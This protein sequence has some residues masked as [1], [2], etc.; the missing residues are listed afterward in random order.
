MKFSGVKQNGKVEIDLF[1][2]S[3]DKKVLNFFVEFSYYRR[4]LRDKLIITPH[5]KYSKYVKI[6]K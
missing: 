3:D 1:F 2:R 6:Q 5:Y 4:L